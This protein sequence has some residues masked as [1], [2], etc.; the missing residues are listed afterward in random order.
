MSD[1]M[2]AGMPQSE[3]MERFAGKFVETR[4]PY[5]AY[6]F[7]FVVDEHMTHTWVHA[8][9]RRLLNK[10]EVM[11][12]VQELRDEAMTST[13]MSAK[14]LIQDWADI[15]NADPNEIVS[16]VAEN[17]RHCRGREFK[18]QWRDAA[19][20]LDACSQAMK[21]RQFPPSDEGGYGFNGAADPVADCPHC[22]GEGHKRVVNHDTRRLSPRA[23]KLYKGAKQKADGTIEVLVHDQHV[24]RESL[25][26]IFGAFKD[27]IDVTPTRE[28]PALKRDADPQENTQTYLRLIQGGKSA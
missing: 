25:A 17:C 13:L 26:K 2:I 12:R 15:A 28:T 20:W 3:R 23:R 22:Y 8:E 9:A 18:F 10:R 24:A 11:L 6:R 21:A 1:P 4:N 27:G 7:A 16:V 14:E 19:E 5:E